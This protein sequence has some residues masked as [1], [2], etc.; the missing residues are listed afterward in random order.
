MYNINFFYF[1]IFFAN[2]LANLDQQSLKNV[3]EEYLGVYYGFSRVNDEP[4]EKMVMSIGWN[5]QFD[6]KERT[7]VRYQKPVFIII[8]IYAYLVGSS[9]VKEIPREF[10]WC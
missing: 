7:L 1:L 4:I 9:R 8:V 10:L 6:N 3:P 5:L 2:Y